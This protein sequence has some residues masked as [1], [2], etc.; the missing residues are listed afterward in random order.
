MESIK[1]PQMCYCLKKFKFSNVNQNVRNRVVSHRSSTT[2]YAHL[3][4]FSGRTSCLS[5]YSGGSGLGCWH[6]MSKETLI[7]CFLLKLVASKHADLDLIN[8]RGWPRFEVDFEFTQYLKLIKFYVHPLRTTRRFIGRWLTFQLATMFG[9]IVLGKLKASIT[10]ETLIQCS[11]VCRIQ[12]MKR[13][14]EKCNF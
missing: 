8:T 6:S 1:F 7:Q 3:L 14:T 9:W 4:R 11:G 10:K 13:I 5:R 12:T 2:A